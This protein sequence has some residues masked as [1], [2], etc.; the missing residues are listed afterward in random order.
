MVKNTQIS[1]L[2]L[3]QCLLH[4]IKVAFEFVFNFIKTPTSAN[5]FNALRVRII[6]DFSVKKTLKKLLDNI[7]FTSIPNLKGFVN[8]SRKIS[9]ANEANSVQYINSLEI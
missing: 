1:N 4:K 6:T 8:R 5:V 3:L 2:R 7:K 9:E